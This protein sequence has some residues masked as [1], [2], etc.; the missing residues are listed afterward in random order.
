MIPILKSIKE[1]IERIGGCRIY[2]NT[3]PRGTDYYFDIKREL[4]RDGVKTVFDV[5]AN[6]GQSAVKYARQFPKAQIYSFEPVVDTYQKLVAATRQFSRVKPYNLGMGRE[7]GKVTIHV[8]PLSETS[9]IRHCRP[10]DRPETIELESIASFA[11]KHQME[12]I[13]FLKVDTEG[14]DLE[15]LAGASALLRQHK[16]RFFLSEC[17]PFDRLRYHTSFPALASFMDG[18]GYTLF[19]VYE[20]FPG[21]SGLLFWNALFYSEPLVG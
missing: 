15:V 21:D 7:P 11:E 18:Y 12:T 8:N 1:S 20:Q 3:L 14:H 19:G 9:S 4:G 10:E 17:E 16:I 13:D 5:G 2:R 6:V